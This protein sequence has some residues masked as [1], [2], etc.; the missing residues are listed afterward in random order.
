MFLRVEGKG[1]VAD[2][3][4][5]LIPTE[6]EYWFREDFTAYWNEGLSAKEIAKEMQ[7]N[8][9]SNA[10]WDLREWHVYYFAQKF[11]LPKRN[12]KSKQRPP[13]ETPTN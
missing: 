8:D 9:P 11:G 1:K 2:E 4:K 7:F 12:R 5:K 6:H 10:P 13:K 3:S